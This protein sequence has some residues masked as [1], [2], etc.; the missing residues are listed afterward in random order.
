MNDITL[1][2]FKNLLLDLYVAQ[3]EIARLTAAPPQL[4]SDDA[5]QGGVDE[6]V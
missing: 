5:P 6:E 2:D 1:D 4:N 3:R